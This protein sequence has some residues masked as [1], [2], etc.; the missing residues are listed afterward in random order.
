M[1]ARP[2]GSSAAGGLLDALRAMGGTLNEMVRI[3][4]ALFAVELR[5][6]VER[7]KHMAVLSALGAAFLHMALVLL[8]FLVAA[9]FWDT[10]RI[11]AIATLVV[12]YLACGI[13]A[14]VRLRAAVAE[15]PP[16]FAASLR[17]LDEDLAQLRSLR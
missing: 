16:P 13:A 14:L 5:E 8:S 3:R 9:V 1:S 10:H 2:L 6:E 17:E 4:G 15:S 7:R 11:A 12:V